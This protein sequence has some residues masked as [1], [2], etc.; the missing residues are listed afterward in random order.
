MYLQYFKVETLTSR[1]LTNLLSFEQLGLDQYQQE[2][3]CIQQFL[4]TSANSKMDLFKF[5]DKYATSDWSLHCLMTLIPQ[6]DRLVQ[7]LRQETYLP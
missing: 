2:L 4:N 1:Q 7:V 3:P 5:K 6:S